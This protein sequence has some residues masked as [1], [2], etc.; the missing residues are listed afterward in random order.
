MIWGYIKQ[1][2]KSVV[3]GIIAC[4]ILVFASL[5]C[6]FM[7]IMVPIFGLAGQVN[8]TDDGDGSSTISLIEIKEIIT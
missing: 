2:L 6:A 4:P 1:Y 3:G 5:F 8:I 7:A